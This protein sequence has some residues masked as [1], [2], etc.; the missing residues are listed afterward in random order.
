VKTITE[1][2]PQAD[3]ELKALESSLGK[4]SFSGNYTFQYASYSSDR[5]NRS[6]WKAA[7]ALYKVIDA[8]AT[9]YTVYCALG[10][11]YCP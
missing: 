8:A 3:A 10:G 7:K 11:K 9:T 1:L 5:S 4:A 2:K 6:L